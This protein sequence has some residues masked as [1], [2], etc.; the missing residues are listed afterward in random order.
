MSAADQYNSSLY[1]YEV[2]FALSMSRNKVSAFE[3]PP[4]VETMTP[5]NNNNNNDNNILTGLPGTVATTCGCIIART[6]MSVLLIV[7]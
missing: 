2:Y 4:L 6:S 7:G 5:A 1:D 3:K